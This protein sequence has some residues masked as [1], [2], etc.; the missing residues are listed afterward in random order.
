MPPT[1][2]HDK[3]PPD[4]EQQ[5]PSPP[6]DSEGGADP[7]GE[8]G[9]PR[10]ADAV[11]QDDVDALLSAAETA[12]SQEQQE[13]AEPA[14][15]EEPRLNAEAEPPGRNVAN[16]PNP[17][18]GPGFDLED[19]SGSDDAKLETARVSMLSDVDL[20]VQIELGR[21][22]MLVEDVLKLGVNSVVELDKL[23]G[24]PVSVYVNDRLI[25]Q[26]EIIVLNDSF[27][28]RVNELATQDPHRV[29]S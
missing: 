22:R 15:P 3:P 7:A 25:A 12:P 1:P 26:G 11:N 10:A 19:I 28:V 20:N 18:K 17:V 29:T 9:N 16:A 8:K 5:Q 14:S 4:E 2:E 24:D 23:A 21:A 27:C 6:T 13:S